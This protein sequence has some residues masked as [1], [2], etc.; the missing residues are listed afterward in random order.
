MT[1]EINGIK[2]AMAETGA[3]KGTIITNSQEDNL[4]GIDLI[5]AW[6]WI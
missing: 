5:P 3:L 4:D 6:K 1:R 2:N